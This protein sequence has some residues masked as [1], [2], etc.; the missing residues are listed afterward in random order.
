MKQILISLLILTINQ[1]AYSQNICDC[2]KTIKQLIQKVENEYPGFNLKV[3]DTISY[4]GYKN[5]IID[6]AKNINENGCYDI[7]KKYTDYFQDGHLILVDKREDNGNSDIIKTETI[8]FNIADFDKYLTKSI[9]SIEGVWTSD[10]YKVGVIKQDSNYLAFLISSEN[11][12]W[13][14]SEIKFKLNKNGNAVYYMGNHK[15]KSDVYSVINNSIIYFKETKVAFVKEQPLPVLSKEEVTKELNELEGFFIKPVSNKTLLLRISSFDYSYTERIENMIETNKSLLEHY[16]NLIIDLRG[17]GGGTDYSYRPI[18]KYIYTNPV[19]HLSGEYLDTQT[20]IDGLSN[21]V[22][23]ADKKKYADEITDIKNDLK[24]M[25]GKIGLFI[26]YDPEANFGYT[27]QDTIYPYPKNVVILANEKSASSTEK[28]ILDAKQSKKV[29]ILGTPTYGA[30]DYVSVREFKLDCEN[31]TL[32][33]PTIRMMRLPDYP[34]DNIGI[35]PDIY[36]DKYVE[37][38]VKFAQKYLE[39]K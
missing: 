6:L 22:E 29:K 25:E 12:N 35:Q 36:M 37:D 14:Q 8:N 28:F 33:M 34:L 11:N 1:T 17:N 38:W 15:Q 32:Y 4:N 16:D 30:V 7:M 9:D 5:H 39:N 27:K 18:L 10:S 26:P 13:K 20:L 23:T 3:K 21:W 31:Y 2:S 24:R 19:R